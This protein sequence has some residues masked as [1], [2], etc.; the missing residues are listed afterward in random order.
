[1]SSATT[2]LKGNQAEEGR[3]AACKRWG[4]RRVLSSPL[5]LPY[6]RTAMPAGA[7]LP[8]PDRATTNP[9]NSAQVPLG[10]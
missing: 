5:L 1:M 4:A 7:E 8:P 2:V 10:T 6:T 3:K 9:P